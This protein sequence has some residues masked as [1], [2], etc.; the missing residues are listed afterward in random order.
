MVFDTL[1]AGIVCIL[2]P[3]GHIS[4]TGFIVSSYLIAT[5]AHV[6]KFAGAKPGSIVT[7]LRLVD[8][9]KFEALVEEKYW[10][11]TEVDVAFLRAIDPFPK[12]TPLKLG[13]SANIADHSFISYGF[14]AN[15]SRELQVRGSILGETNDRSR[16]ELRSREIVEGVSGAPVFDQQTQRVVGMIVERTK[17]D[18]REEERKIRIA[19]GHEVYSGSIPIVASTGRLQGKRT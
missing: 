14:P 4:G 10:R 8:Q 19:K 18:I 17:P 13:S 15:L 7:C 11:D 3:S 5:C 9:H 12:N 1:R 16:L 2:K 6:I